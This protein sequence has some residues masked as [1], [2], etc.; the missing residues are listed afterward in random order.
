MAQTQAKKKAAALPQPPWKQNVGTGSEAHPD[1]ELG[2]PAGNRGVVHRGGQA[3]ERAAVEGVGPG[4]QAAVAR[5]IVGGASD[6]AL[7]GEGDLL[8]QAPVVV[9]QVPEV[10]DVDVELGLH[11]LAERKG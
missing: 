9:D 10:Q 7:V 4:A 11:A 6:G 8:L 5:G 3:I 1:A 2:L